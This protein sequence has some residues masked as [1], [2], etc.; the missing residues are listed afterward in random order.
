MGAGGAI[1]SQDRQ[2]L[3]VRP[4]S[5]CRPSMK[6]VLCAAAWVSLAPQRVLSVC[7]SRFALTSNAQMDVAITLG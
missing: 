4:L 3:Q 6:P 7:E 1:V 5:T 2:E